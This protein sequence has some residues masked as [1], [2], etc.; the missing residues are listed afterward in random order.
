[1]DACC[2]QTSP[3]RW[4]LQTL[5]SLRHK[6]GFNQTNLH[7]WQNSGNVIYKPES[8]AVSPVLSVSLDLLIGLDTNCGRMHWSY[9]TQIHHVIQGFVIHPLTALPS[10]F[11]W[12]LHWEVVQRQTWSQT[13]NLWFLWLAYAWQPPWRSSCYERW[14][15][16]KSWSKEQRRRP[17]H[18]TRGRKHK[19]TQKWTIL[20][21]Y[22]KKHRN[23]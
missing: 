10:N 19:N 6:G 8:L 4:L 7:Q 5:T 23:I 3:L 14:L 11:Y 13:C 20:Y 1:M 12:F 9:S 18:W 17:S 15:G 16:P 2:W 22:E 21:I